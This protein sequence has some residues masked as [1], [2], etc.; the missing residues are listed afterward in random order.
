MQSTILKL[1]KKLKHFRNVFM[2]IEHVKY[3][4]VVGK[5]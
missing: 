2:F 1:E 4:N 5:Y 3:D